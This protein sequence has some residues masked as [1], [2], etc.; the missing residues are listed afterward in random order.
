MGYRINNRS[1]VAENMI[2]VEKIPGSVLSY[3]ILKRMLKRR[4]GNPPLIEN[5]IDFNEQLQPNGFELTVQK[6]EKFSQ[7]D[8]GR[9]G[10]DNLDRKLPSTYEIQFDEAGWLF[11][12]MGNYKII[13]NEKVNIPKDIMAI[14]APRSSLLRSGVSIETA[15]WDAGYSGRSESLLIVYSESGFY[16]KKNARLLQLIFIKLSKVSRFGKAYEG[17]YY[18]EHESAKQHGLTD[19]GV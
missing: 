16:V 11:L 14:G 18:L 8:A 9:I 15:I 13:F 1:K 6:V 19:Y 12:P 17:V 10:F 7:K 2:E 5:A 4:N 3:S